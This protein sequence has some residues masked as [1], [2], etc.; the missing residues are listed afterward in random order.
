M[1][2][3]S[4]RGAAQDVLPVLD[5]AILPIG[6]AV[7]GRPQQAEKHAS[8]HAEAL[9]P[10]PGRQARPAGRV[11]SQH[12]WVCGS[13]TPALPYGLPSAAR[14]PCALLAVTMTCACA[15]ALKTRDPALG[16]GREDV[17][18]MLNCEGRGPARP[19]R[20]SRPP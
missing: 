3:R 11:Q 8:T 19:C 6:H 18:E 7:A 9:G 5:R 20:P 4:K 13:G 16:A 14:D 15:R 1:D 17:I 12:S 2:P 10:W